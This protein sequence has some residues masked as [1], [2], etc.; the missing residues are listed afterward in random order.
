MDDIYTFVG[1]IREVA[2][3]RD[4]HTVQLNLSLQL[5]G[6]VKRW[7]KLELTHDDKSVL[8]VSANDVTAWID[9]LVNRF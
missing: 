5:R 4:P 8:Y 9:A 1:R 6:K 3:I 7:F 2:D